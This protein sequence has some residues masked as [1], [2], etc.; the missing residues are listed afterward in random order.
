MT[1]LYESAQSSTRTRRGR[2]C[3]GSQSSGGGVRVWSGPPA[4]SV[5]ATRPTSDRLCWRRWR[6]ADGPTPARRTRVRASF[7]QVPAPQL[8]SI[9][10]PPNDP[11][12]AARLGRGW[13]AVGRGDPR[14]DHRDAGRRLHAGAVGVEIIPGLVVGVECVVVLDAAV[15]H[16]HG[17]YVGH[18][19]AG[20]AVDQLL[21]RAG[22]HLRVVLPGWPAGADDVA[23]NRPLVADRPA[24]ARAPPLERDRG[25]VQGGP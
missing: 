7:P 8:P 10:L 15:G 25:G 21:G 9:L 17:A 12:V 22:G 4:L 2:C 1:N 18:V 3:R 16:G 14:V 20:S 19:H 24:V 13:R 11:V 5:P 6:R 23:C